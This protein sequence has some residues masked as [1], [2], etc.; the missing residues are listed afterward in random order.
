M[1]LQLVP[2]PS[3]TTIVGHQQS[4]ESRGFNHAMGGGGNG[5][6]A[7]KPQK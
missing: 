5:D 2:L 3:R 7:V 4:S 1:N 6:I